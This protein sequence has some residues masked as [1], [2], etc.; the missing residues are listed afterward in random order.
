[1]LTLKTAPSLLLYFLLLLC[2]A[3]SAGLTQPETLLKAPDTS[4]IQ[5]G[6]YNC[7]AQCICNVS[8]AYFNAIMV[9]VSVL[10]MVWCLVFI[11]CYVILREL[12]QKPGEV[13]LILA[14]T[15]FLL[16]IKYIV[17]GTQLLNSDPTTP[18][19]TD[20]ACQVG[21]FIGM[22]L[23]N[24]ISFYQLTFYLY[25]VL[26]LRNPI[27]ASKITRK[28]YHSITILLS[29]ALTIGEL[30]VGGIGRTIM[31]I[32]SLKSTPD[33]A[34]PAA[35]DGVFF[36]SSAFLAYMLRRNISQ[37]RKDLNLKE[38][39]YAEHYLGYLILL[40]IVLVGML[41]IQ[42]DFSDRVNKALTVANIEKYRNAFNVLGLCAL[43]MF[44]LSSFALT[45]G[46]VRDSTVWKPLKKRL[47]YILCC[48]WRNSEY[49]E[50]HDR[51]IEPLMTTAS[52]DAVIA[53]AKMELHSFGAKQQGVK[54]L[55][56]S[57]PK[58]F[59]EAPIV[60]QNLVQKKKHPQML[61]T[62]FA[63]VLYH[64]HMQKTRPRKE[65]SI[66]IEA[67]Y[68]DK[69]AERKKKFVLHDTVLRKNLPQMYKEIKSK[70]LKVRFGIFT[71]H[72][73]GLF[74]DLIEV[75]R[76]GLE[77]QNSFDLIK[78]FNHILHAESIGE[79]FHFLTSDNKFILRSI[80]KN[81][82]RCLVNIL[83][84]YVEYL[85]NNSS[86]LLARI[87]GIYKF[88]VMSPYHQ[89]NCVIMKN[90]S[91]C[92]RTSIER[93]YQLKGVNLDQLALA[94]DSES[95]CSG[96][97]HPGRYCGEEC[98]EKYE[99]ALSVDQSTREDLLETVQRDVQFLIGQGL[100]DYTLNVSLVNRSHFVQFDQRL[101]SS[102]ILEV[103]ESLEERSMVMESSILSHKE[104]LEEDEESKGH[105][106][107]E[108]NSKR[109]QSPRMQ[110]HVQNS[111]HAIRS[112]REN[113][114]YSIE[115]DNLLTQ[116][117]WKNRMKK[118]FCLGD[119][120]NELPPEVYGE[121]FLDYTKQIL[122]ERE[123]ISEFM[124]NKEAEIDEC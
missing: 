2:T 29:L 20:Q 50:E 61:C 51:I 75:D 8:Q 47:H 122:S 63:G 59:P 31:G 64:W 38:T 58:G 67:Q 42:I 79:Q 40:C 4:C 39:R 92:S 105:N 1:M 85:K 48:Q 11:F 90:V 30:M 120:N 95:Q 49:L 57:A 80:T 72:A 69:S 44:T 84:Q 32:C 16:A 102:V 81:E 54:P 76:V 52:G 73:S 87:Y 107:E 99:R 66:D 23:T 55:S 110:V 12:R 46:Q 89:I 118:F 7:S 43:F 124:G 9:G 117:T 17:E 74:K 82:R 83:P 121:R 113:L 112:T 103:E 104:E 3:H 60:S 88:E 62:M 35:L 19:T 14:V 22:F 100:F 13:I 33:F 41:A 45:M 24:T 123:E 97:R 109:E 71:S 70:N 93:M 96:L 65:I 25:K 21:G 34:I 77:L 53:E 94:T 108:Y 27:S 10:T 101:S 98:F 26:T 5:N 18:R 106:I 6:F 36:L 114:Y 78:N 56:L 116:Y 68:N 119:S 91:E 15:N 111:F 28:R 86:S 37:R 115:I